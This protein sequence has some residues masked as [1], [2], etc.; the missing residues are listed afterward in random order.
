V[1]HNAAVKQARADADNLK[2]RIEDQDRRVEELVDKLAAAR[3]ELKRL[4]DALAKAD[5]PGDLKDDADIKAKLSEIE[6][7]NAR[8]RQNLERQKALSEAEGYA[9]EYRSLTDQIEQNQKELRGLLDEAD[10]PLKNLSVQDGVLTFKGQPWDCMSGAEQL[11]VAAAI[12]Q[13]V[14]PNMGFV[15]IDRIEMM[16]MPTLNTFGRWLD[17]QGLQAITTRVSTGPECS[18]I[19][20]DGVSMPATG[21]KKNVGKS[22]SDFDFD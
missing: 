22:G 12:C 9:E 19:I 4:Q 10:M 6:E 18:I 8:V 3:T 14:N 11:V 5:D 2:R 20:E 1:S 17:A 16:D 7:K 13:R 15:L 21:G